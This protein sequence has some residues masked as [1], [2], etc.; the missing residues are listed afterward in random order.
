MIDQTI[1]EFSFT[2]CNLEFA[3]FYGLKLKKQVFSNCS[4]ISADFMEADLS[5]AMFDNCNLHRTFF[6][7][8]NAE[9]ADFYTSYNYDIDPE[10][11]RIKKAIFS[12]Q[13]LAG[14]L[15][16]HQLVLK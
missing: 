13:G 4:L 9:G 1:F 8:A 11:T 10:S 14:L 2:D 12:A 16:K 3:Q 7:K 6:E 15:T 5:M